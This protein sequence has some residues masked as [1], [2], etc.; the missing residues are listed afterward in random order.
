MAENGELTRQDR[1]SNEAKSRYEMAIAES[2]SNR[3]KLHVA[4]SNE[5]TKHI[6]IK[7]RII[8]QLK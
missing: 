5:H 1:N 8:D 2:C 3:P 6:V 7:Y 4:C